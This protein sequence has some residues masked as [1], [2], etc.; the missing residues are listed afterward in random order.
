MDM[1]VSRITGCNSYRL[2]IE[3]ATLS[4]ES[5]LFPHKLSMW[6]P[7]PSVLTGGMHD[8]LSLIPTAKWRWFASPDRSWYVLS[9]EGVRYH[10]FRRFFFFLYPT[11]LSLSCHAV[12]CEE[13]MTIILGFCCCCF[14]AW[15]KHCD[16]LAVWTKACL[17]RIDGLCSEPV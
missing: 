2:L 11:S 13:N 6:P 7:R 15:N 1:L 14:P 12:S 16:I 10:L 17:F 8:N 9:S 5:R 4:S 3:G